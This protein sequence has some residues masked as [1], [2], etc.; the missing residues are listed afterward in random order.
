GHAFG[1][2]RL[3][4]TI[5]PGK[6]IEGGVGG[7]LGGIAGALLMCR[8]GLP[9]L[10]LAHVASLGAVAAVLGIAGDLFES[11]L[12]RWAGVKDSGRL[13]P[14]HGGMLDRLDSLLFAA[15]VIYYYF[16]AL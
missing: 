16:Y 6:T 15:P 5:S 3:A 2:H 12:K 9:D 14:G 8:F 13:F 1:R 11:M 4:P 10:P 7:V